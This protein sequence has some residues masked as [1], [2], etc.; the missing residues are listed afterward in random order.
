MC[1]AA[2]AIARSDRF[3]WVLASNRDEFFGR[4]AL[5]LAW[6]QPEGGGPPVLS[7]RDL[8]AGGTWL[9][10]TEAGALALVTNVREPGRFDPG[11]A[12]RGSLVLDWLRQA[13][14]APSVQGTREDPKLGGL[15]EPP[16]NGFNFYAADLV[17]GS[18]AGGRASVWF[19]NR[20]AAPRYLGAGVFGLS[21]A[22]LDAPWPKVTLLKQRLQA[23]LDD[24]GDAATLAATVFEALADRHRAP[25]A[26]LPSTGVPLLRER[27]LS[28]A[29]ICIED[30][31]TGTVYGT[32]CATV[33]IVERTPPGLQAHVIERTFG[34]EGF[35]THEV[36]MG[37]RL[38]ASAA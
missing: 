10:L 9:G 37:W 25:D 33:V 5:P 19:S 15:S 17:A 1:L 23:A 12:S 36:G 22:A 34:P 32:R 6:W 20:A 4:P 7:G 21:N 18:N 31:T 26:Q 30:A 28:S 29:H 11:A 35:V 3:P 24:P 8:A 2:I 16:R 38:P 14:G 13:P 27:Q